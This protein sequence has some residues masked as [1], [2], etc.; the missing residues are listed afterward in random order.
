MQSLSAHADYSELLEWLRSTSTA[1]DHTFV[2]HGQPAA[3][4]AMRRRIRDHL[5]W[6]AEVPTMG[7]QVTLH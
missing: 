4:D 2:V 5:G 1:P 6:H 7:Q 3:Q